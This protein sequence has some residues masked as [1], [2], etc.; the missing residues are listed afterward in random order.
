MR[1]IFLFI[2]LLGVAFGAVGKNPQVAKINEAMKLLNQAMIL[3]K[4]A[5]IMAD[6]E[7]ILDPAN[8]Q[9]ALDYMKEGKFDQ[10]K[11]ILIVF[12]RKDD[13]KGY[14]AF[15]WLGICLLEEKSYEKAMLAFTSYLNKIGQSELIGMNLDMK[16]MAYKYLV[17]C[18]ERLHRPIDACAIIDKFEHE[19]ANEQ[20]YCNNARDYLKCQKK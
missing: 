1:I 11:Q 18:Y 9:K 4:E 12:S 14:Q 13:Q 8:Y 5:S 19:F 2:A 10:A 15:Y 6:E 16:K 17:R 7:E 20:E 3:L